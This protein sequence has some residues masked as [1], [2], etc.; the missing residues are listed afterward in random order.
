VAVIRTY[1]LN[2]QGDRTLNL[3]NSQRGMLHDGCAPPKRRFLLQPHGV[4]SQK[5]FFI[6]TAVKISRKTEVFGASDQTNET[7]SVAFIPQANYTYRA[8]ATCWRNLVPTFAD[9]GMSRG[10]RG[11][12]PTVVNI[13][14]LDRSRYFSFK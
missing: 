8:T 6:F 13:S 4:I 1:R 14:F 11:G 7:N 2:L 5:T 3:P 9:R 12:S 10:Q